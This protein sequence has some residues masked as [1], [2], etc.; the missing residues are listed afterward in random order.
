MVGR[1]DPLWGPVVGFGVGGVPTE[2]LGDRVVRS[3]PLTAAESQALVLAPRAAALL[4][5]HRG[6]PRL[7]TAALATVVL[8]VAQLTADLPAVARV[9]LNPVVAH[10]SGCS[11]L[12]AALELGP[13]RRADT[14]PRRLT[15]RPG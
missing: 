12:R 5:G 8:A 4:T 13:P 1:E 9:E 2:L 15:V 14:G 11:V 6:S 7:D 10:T 3:A